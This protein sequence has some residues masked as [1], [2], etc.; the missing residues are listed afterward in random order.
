MRLVVK[1]TTL[2]YCPYCHS[3]M[4][5]HDE[6]LISETTLY[7]KELYNVRCKKCGATGYLQ[8]NWDKEGEKNG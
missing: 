1:D 2:I 6:P 5:K 7:H 4:V 8:E 3:S